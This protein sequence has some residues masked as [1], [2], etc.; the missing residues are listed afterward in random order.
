MGKYINFI[1][2]EEVVSY[3]KKKKSDRMCSFSE[4]EGRQNDR[5]PLVVRGGGEKKGVGSCAQVDRMVLDMNISS[6]EV[7]RGK[8][9]NLLKMQGVWW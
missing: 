7:T 1:F 3:V 8:G 6:S 4:Q 9:E 2:P 5:E